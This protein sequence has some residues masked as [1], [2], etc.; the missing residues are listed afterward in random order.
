MFATLTGM[1][2][3]YVAFLRGINV[4]NRR[5]KS[6]ALAAIFQS[7]GFEEVKVLIA[8]GNVLFGA[9]ETDEG[10]L[11]RTVEDGLERALNY[12][13]SVMLRSAAEVKA[14]LD[15][16][17]FKGIEVT[18]AT[19]LYVTLLADKTKS[20]MKLPYESLGGELTILSKTDREVFSVLTLG[21]TGRTVD[22]M[23]IIEKEYGKAATTRNWNTIQQIAAL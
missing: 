16:D 5:V 6:D 3:R 7:L 2:N 17:P 19:R 1:A 8:S 12:K 23:T 20:A 22:A 10:R 4:G 14:L 21:K 9:D 18:K 11:T 15:S 13:V